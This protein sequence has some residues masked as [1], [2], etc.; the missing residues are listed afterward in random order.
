[1]TTHFH[2]VKSFSWQEKINKNFHLKNGTGV[3]ITRE[4][5]GTASKLA[6]FKS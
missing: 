1:M 5:L 3:S 4:S 6:P 2:P